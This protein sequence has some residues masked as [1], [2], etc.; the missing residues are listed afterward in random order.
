MTLDPRVRVFNLQVFFSN[1]KNN[2]VSSGFY[3]PNIF[4]K[5]L[6]Q[7]SLIMNNASQED[8]DGLLTRIYHTDIPNIGDKLHFESY[9]GRHVN[10]SY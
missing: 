10:F 1:Y 5:I 9:G 2:I 3:W 7:L 8:L 6:N 4:Y